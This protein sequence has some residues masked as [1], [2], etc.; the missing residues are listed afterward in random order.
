V[1]K[2]NRGSGC[3]QLDDASPYSENS[4]AAE[5][6]SSVSVAYVGVDVYVPH[7]LDLG[8]S[9]RWVVSF[10]P[11]PLYPRGKSPRYPLDRRLGG[12]QSRSGHVQKRKSLTLPGLELQPLGRSARSQSLY[13]LRYPGT[14]VNYFSSY[15][16]LSAIRQT[17]SSAKFACASR[18]AGHRSPWSAKSWTRST[19]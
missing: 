5:A 1:P 15:R 10:T 11:Q 6:N 12:P 9:W 13:R 2:L 8:T 18:H 17:V 16:T 3:C 19:Q 4:A 7:F 14:E